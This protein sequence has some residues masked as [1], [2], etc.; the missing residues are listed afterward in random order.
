MLDTI[1]GS[2]MRDGREQVGLTTVDADV[3]LKMCPPNIV[4]AAATMSGVLF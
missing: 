4:E 1:L 2:V 3:F